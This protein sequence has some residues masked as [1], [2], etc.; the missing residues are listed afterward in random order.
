MGR[1]TSCFFQSDRAG[2]RDVNAILEETVKEIPDNQYIPHPLRQQI[3]QH[4]TNFHHS[5]SVFIKNQIQPLL[6][7]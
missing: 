4:I 1:K 3:E 2:L 6:H 7:H 5:I